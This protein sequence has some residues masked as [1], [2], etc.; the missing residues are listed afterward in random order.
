MPDP[1]PPALTMLATIKLAIKDLV[2]DT[3]DALLA[4]LILEVTG[5][6]ERFCTRRF[7]YG[8][9][10]ELSDGTGKTTLLVKGFPVESVTWLKIDDVEIVAADYDVNLELGEINYEAGFTEGFQNMSVKYKCGY[11]INATG[12]HPPDEMEGAVVDEVVARYYQITMQP[13]PSGEGFVDRRTS[14][15]TASALKYFESQ[16]N[17][18]V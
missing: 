4:R 7:L 14:F 10:T 18:N 1:T 16:R 9:F 12:K 6:A 17:I 11:D 15:L 3:Q 2:G 5:F 8:E 13:Q